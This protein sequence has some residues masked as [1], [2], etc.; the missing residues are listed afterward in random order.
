MPIYEYDCRQCGAAFETLV[1]KGKTPACPSCGSLELER[2]F[3][4]PSVKSESTHA[5]AMRAAKKRDQ[6]TAVDRVEAQRLYEKNH[7]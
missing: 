1:R 6:K 5:L 7:D 2:R 4:L 3:S